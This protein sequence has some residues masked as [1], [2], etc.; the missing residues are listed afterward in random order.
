MSLGIWLSQTV[1]V[2]GT[3]RTCCCPE[4]Q[5]GLAAASVSASSGQC[6]SLNPCMSHVQDLLDSLGDTPPGYEWQFGT[7]EDGLEDVPRAF[8][9]DTGLEDTEDFEDE[10]AFAQ[11]SPLWADLR[12]SIMPSSDDSGPRAFTHIEALREQ[13]ELFRMMQVRS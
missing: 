5:L 2:V 9:Q 6:E 4:R 8:Q 1:T 12:E 11:G 7:G 13:G 10:A 3:C